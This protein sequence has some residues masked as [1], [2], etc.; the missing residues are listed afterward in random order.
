VDREKLE[1]LL[2]VGPML[3]EDLDLETLLGRIVEA[4][5]D[6]TGAHYAALGVLDADGTALER[7]LTSGLADEEIARIGDLPRG[8]GVL[9]EL[10]R[11]PQPL[12]LTDVGDHPRSYGFPVGH[13]PMHGFLGVPIR[14]RGEVYGNL[15]LTE[16]DGGEFDEEDEEVVSRLADWAGVAIDNARLYG[17]VTQRHADLERTVEVLETNVEIA[18]AIGAAT[19]L[20]PVLELIVKR[21]RALVEARAVAVG[22]VSGGELALV[23]VAGP[24]GR[25]LIGSRIPWDADTGDPAAMPDGLRELLARDA[26]ADA[27]LS[28]PLIFRDQKLGILAAVDRQVQGPR[29]NE[30]DK[31]LLSAF[32]A[33]ASIA[34][35]SAQR[36]TQRALRQSLAASERERTR[37]ARELHDET[38]QDLAALRV[39]LTGARNAADVDSLAAAVEQAIERLAEMS[40]AL[41]ALI[42]DLRPALLDQLGL[43]PALRSLAERGAQSWSLPIQLEADLAYESGRSPDRLAPDLELGVYRVVQEA[44]TNAAKHAEASSVQVRI[45]EEDAVLRV[46][47]RDDGR[48]FDTSAAHEGFGLTG[49]RERIEQHG[50]TLGVDSTL[51]GGTDVVA[52]IPVRRAGERPQQQSASAAW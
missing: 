41:R 14:V 45:V 8:R 33:S 20:E 22:L 25:D 35:A 23:T 15:Y 5:R 11:H 36:A 43:E 31:R 29:F 16:K 32:A 46:L 18:R 1:Q 19:D 30:H 37:W 44:L 2:S 49:M 12:R 38:L 13:P 51:E 50:G 17:S 24:L 47:V 42:S 48:G 3:A 28:V 9:G 39:L 6:L 34:V 10:I 40:G 52:E 21:A 4:A 26:G 7:F 27:V